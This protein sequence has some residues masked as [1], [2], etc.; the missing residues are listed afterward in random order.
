VDGPRG[1]PLR[2]DA[3]AETANDAEPAFLARPDG[4]PIYHGFPILEDVAVDGFRL[5]MITD[6]EAESCDE[7]D[8]FIVA[9]DDSRCGLVWEIGGDPFVAAAALVPASETRWG[10]WSVGLPH[11]MNSR[12]NARRNLVYVLDELRPRWERWRADRSRF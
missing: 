1:R 9:P 8:A 11:P 2:L 4:A 5:G 3:G 6:W 10:V 7:G 12:E